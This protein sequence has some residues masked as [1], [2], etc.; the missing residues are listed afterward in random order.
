MASRKP[1]AS[2]PETPKKVVVKQSRGYSDE[3]RKRM[4]LIGNGALEIARKPKKEKQNGPKTEE[5]MG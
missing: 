2:N 3:L 4:E 5:E 1:A